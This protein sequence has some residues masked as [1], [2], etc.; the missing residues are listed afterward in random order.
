M[1]LRGRAGRVFGLVAAVALAGCAQGIGTG[2]GLG[3]GSGAGG[4]E[5]AAGVPAGDVAAPEVFQATE[6]GLWDGRPSLGGIWVAH[7]DVTD[8]EKVLIRNAAN[9]RSV[10]GALFRRERA[11]P[12]PRIQVS[13]EA[14]AELGMLAGAPVELGVTALRPAPDPT[15]AT[16]DTG[17][18][19]DTETAEAAE[20]ADT[21]DTPEARPGGLARFWT[22]LTG[23]ATT[24][25]TAQET[26]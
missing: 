19:E 10:T 8:P 25:A 13:S 24:V 23:S 20:T 9:G 5:T 3:I 21:A 1:K 16:G 15:P 6:A 17:P 26:E 11:M 18:A 14:A 7:P 2:I 4:A 22:G 12:G